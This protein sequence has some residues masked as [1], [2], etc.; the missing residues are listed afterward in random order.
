MQKENSK[1]SGINT[2][3][4]FLAGAAAGIYVTNYLRSEK[5][6]QT[7]SAVREKIL[8][9]EGELQD[10]LHTQLEKLNHQ[11]QE[12]VSS[13]KVHIDQ[14]NEKSLA[15]VEEGKEKGTDILEKGLET[16]I[17]KAEAIKEKAEAIK[18]KLAN[19]KAANQSHIA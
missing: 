16:T 17:Q 7:V 12:L 3:F 10:N 13:M 14:L 15:L 2:F 4:T 6:K 19:E 8:T 11:Y 1:N 9:V 5:G 18:E